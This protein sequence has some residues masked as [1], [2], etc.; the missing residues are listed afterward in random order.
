MERRSEGACG[1]LSQ[2]VI[3]WR[4]EGEEDWTVFTKYLQDT[5]SNMDI[6]TPRSSQQVCRCI[7][8]FAMYNERKSN[9]EEEVEA[10]KIQD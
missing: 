2:Y 10:G 5:K 3:K 1:L 8:R 7:G 6:V 4:E 9:V